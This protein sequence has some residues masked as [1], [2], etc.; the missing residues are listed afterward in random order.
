MEMVPG[1][2][3][4]V[5]LAVRQ[6]AMQ[7]EALLE[8]LLEAATEWGAGGGSRRQLLGRAAPMVRGRVEAAGLAAAADPGRWQSS[9]GCRLLLQVRWLGGQATAAGLAG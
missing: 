9:R 7:D 2:N 1:L 3:R 8:D 4:E 5:Y 6:D